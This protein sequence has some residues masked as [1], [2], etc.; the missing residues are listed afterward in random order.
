MSFKTFFINFV[1]LMLLSMNVFSQK[2]NLKEEQDHTVI[3]KLL[4][5]ITVHLKEKKATDIVS[6]FSFGF[7]KKYG[8]IIWKEGGNIKGMKVVFKNGGLKSK[9]V[10]SSQINRSI[11]E[12]YFKD[13]CD[14]KKTFKND[15]SSYISHDF[16]IY[17]KTISQMNEQELF[18]MY[19][20]YMA[21]KDTPC[22]II[23]KELMRIAD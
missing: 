22:A 10:V 2:S 12:S 23:V 17:V 14:L 11:F 3:A 20:S 4:D 21:N 13:K 9:K 19:S 6:F 7:A 16:T 5:S 18:F 1:I 8:C 15:K